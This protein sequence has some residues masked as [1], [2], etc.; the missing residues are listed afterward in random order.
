MSWILLLS[1]LRRPSIKL[2]ISEVQ[3]NIRRNHKDV[4]DIKDKHIGDMTADELSDD[5][6]DI[7]Q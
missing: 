5:P 3:K 7:A 2:H 6:A 4:Q 1:A